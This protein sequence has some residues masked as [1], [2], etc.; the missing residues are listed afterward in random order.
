MTTASISIPRGATV[1]FTVTFYDDTGAVTQPASAGIN[2]SFATAGT[3]DLEALLIP[4]T[5]P[6]AP[7]VAWTAQW[8]T[9]DVEP[10]PVSWSAYGK[11]SG[12]GVPKAVL[13]GQFELTANN[14]NL[15]TF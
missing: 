10:G 2:L 15:A 12:L 11:S 5:P 13:D 6:S 4:M 9:T 14:A 7:A 3:C 1:Q 8:D